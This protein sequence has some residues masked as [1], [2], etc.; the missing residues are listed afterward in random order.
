MNYEELLSQMQGF[1]KEMGDLTKNQQKSYKSLC[2]NM[3]SGDLKNLSK[4]I[5]TL[6]A[7]CES[8]EST[9]RAMQEVSEGF[10]S[11]AYIESGEFAE[12]M[13][14]CCQK[15]GVDVKGEFP[16]YEMFP[17]KVR[18][19]VENLDMYIDRKKVQCLRPVSFINGIKAEQDKLLKASFNP[20]I[21]ANELAQAYDLTLMKQN[22]GKAYAKDSDCY[23]TNIYKSL[24]PM[25][26]FK[27][28]YDQQSFAFD[29]ARLYSAGIE[30]TDDGRKLQF[31]SSRNIKQAI[32]IL[33]L[34]GEEQYL[35]TIRFFK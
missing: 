14:L 16:L 9:L 24:T 4:D 5:T 23:L 27:K 17:Y 6:K 29:L 22:A 21:F 18:V 13:L 3:E 28:D 7:L 20:A 32:R 35:A 19:D 8:Y 30:A 25:R 34:D 26:R 10:D 2:K 12:Q 15:T 33:D 31:G 11:K 1:A